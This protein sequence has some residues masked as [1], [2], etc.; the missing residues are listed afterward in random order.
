M[1]TNLKNLLFFLLVLLPVSTYGLEFGDICIPS[2]NV[3]ICDP[4]KLLKCVRVDVSQHKCMCD[5]D[6]SQENPLVPTT[7]TKYPEN[8]G[9]SCEHFVDKDFCR[10]IDNSYCNGTKCVCLETHFDVRGRCEKYAEHTDEPCLYVQACNRI[11]EPLSAS[12]SVNGFCTC[13]PTHYS[14][15]TN[16]SCLPYRQLLDQ[17]CDVVEQCSRIGDGIG[18][19]CPQNNKVCSCDTTN[20]LPHP[21]STKCLSYATVLGTDCTVGTEQCSRIPFATCNPATTTCACNANYAAVPNLSEC[22]PLRENL[23]LSCIPGS[24]P[25]QC[26]L[27]DG[28]FCT[29]SNNTCVCNPATHYRNLATC[30]TLP[31]KPEDACLLQQ[32]CTQ[33]PYTLCTGGRCQCADGYGTSVDGLRCILTAT[34]VNDPCTGNE[35]CQNIGNTYCTNSVCTC[36]P[37]TIA[38][39]DRRSCLNIIFKLNNPCTES[40]QCVAG[41]GTNSNCRT[42]APFVC[43]CNT[44][45]VGDTLTQDRDRCLIVSALISLK[46][47]SEILNLFNMYFQISSINGTCEARAQCESALG[48]L[49]DCISSRCSCM[50]GAGYLNS[51]CFRRVP[52]RSPCENHEQ[53]VVG[54]N[55]NAACIP[56]SDG[57]GAS[58]CQC[59][60]G[61]DEELGACYGSPGLGEQCVDDYECTRYIN[62]SVACVDGTCWC[63]SS[64]PG[65][66]YFFCSGVNNVNFE[67]HVLLVAL[68]AA[69]T[70]MYVVMS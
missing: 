43:S 47:K 18:V 51:T 15:R 10:K 16:G 4:A 21:E 62:G 26:S 22:V 30:Q 60:P 9:E 67:G 36:V 14:Y 48:P 69:M 1:E 55:A 64:K 44:G 52:L 8:A 37:N 56:S 27:I 65:G 49:S 54:S 66:S 7:C 40:S 25:E 11:P 34:L 61:K 31:A 59:L 3:N 63:D 23:D 2:D 70:S 17:Q 28:A 42:T 19:V 35:T 12:C 53:C 32:H 57:G 41:I 68:W 58:T 13:N 6:L 33:V 20:Y 5:T 29:I 38:A 50:N 24:T 46:N 39:G 45:Y